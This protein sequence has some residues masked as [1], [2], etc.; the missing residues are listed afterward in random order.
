MISAANIER[1]AIRWHTLR[2]SPDW[3]ET[4]QAALEIWLSESD[5]HKIALWRAEFMGQD[6]HSIHLK[7]ANQ[8]APLLRAAIAASAALIIGL[9]L[10]GSYSTIITPGHA[11]DTAVGIQKHIPLADGTTVELNTKTNLRAA[12]TSTRRAVWLQNGEAFFTV[13]HDPAHPFVIHAGKHKVTVL[14]TRFSVRK[15]GDKLEVRVEE[16]RVRVQN[17][18]ANAPSD[19]QI[20][21]AGDIIR[22]NDT[23]HVIAR[24]ETARVQN[25]LSW[26]TGRL[27]FDRTPLREVAAEFNRYN[28]KQ[29]LITDTQ[30]ADIRIGGSFEATNVEAFSQ[31]LNQGFG[32]RIKTSDK[33]IEVSR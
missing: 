12:V 21:Q 22:L 32:L 17:G 8:N 30:T 11:Y 16:G 4:D 33:K 26:R 1:E 2:K 31:L 3:S 23:T 5:A 10:W 28:E 6:D 19:M 25:E 18:L 24:G 7:A 20:A 14:G 27:V 13:A 15:E 29:L 9:G